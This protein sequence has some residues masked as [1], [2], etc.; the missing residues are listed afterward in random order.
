VFRV[1]SPGGSAVASDTIWREVKCVR[2]AGKPVVVSMGAVAGSGGYYVACSADHIVATP[3]T[4]TGSIGVVGGKPVTTGLTERIG[5]G[6]GAVHRGAHALMYSRH[7]PFSESEQERLDAWLDR[8]YADFTGKVADGRGMTV[9]AV[10]EVAKGRVW[11]GADA[12][13]IGLV[14]S[15]GGFRD[16]VAIARERAGLPADAPLRPAISVPPIA[17]L[18]PPTSSED[19]RAAAVGLS[20]WSDGWG[21][22][23]ALASAADWPAFGPLTMT[24]VRLS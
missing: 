22:F 23:G 13:G 2:E 11:T 7:Q 20:M 6:Y 15:L 24:S 9:E 18:R 16:A 10:H 12:V 17:K 14:D 19:P 1:D 21:A 8:I 4:L 3:A 5:L